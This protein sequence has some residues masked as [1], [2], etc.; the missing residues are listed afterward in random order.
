MTTNKPTLRIMRGL[1]G[2]GKSTRALQWVNENPDW[3][4]RVN[5][6]DLRFSNYGQYYGLSRHQEENITSLQHTLIEKALKAGLSVVDDNVNL[7]SSY[8]RDL[9]RIANRVNATIEFDDVDVDVETAIERNAEREKFVNPE[10]IRDFAKRYLKKGKLPAVPPNAPTDESMTGKAA[11]WDESLPPAIWVDADGTFFTMYD[12]EGQ[13]H[14]GAF[15]WHKVHLDKPRPAVVKAVKLYQAAGYAIIVMSGR[16][17]VCK[18]ATT[19]AF[20]DAGVTPT[21]VL[22]RPHKSQEKD[23]KVKRDLYWENVAGKYNIEVALD[24]RDQVVKYTREVLGIDVFQVAYG[25]F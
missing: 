17:E 5:R 23:W 6:D 22:M 9:Y 20:I 13:A 18:E 11:V 7:R 19:Q 25:N 8:V 16:D 3:R 21:M 15:D 12:E 10:V 4:L 24:D 2:S 14:R 1:P